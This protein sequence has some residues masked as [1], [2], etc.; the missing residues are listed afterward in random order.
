MADVKQTTTQPEA[1]RNPFKQLSVLVP[2]LGLL[3]G[4]FIRNGTVNIP[5]LNI[6]QNNSSK[7]DAQRDLLDPS[8]E[9]EVLYYLPTRNVDK[10]THVMEIFSKVGYG[11]MRTEN[12]TE[13]WHVMWTFHN[14]FYPR[15]TEP[16]PDLLPNIM[17]KLK[18]HQKVNQIPGASYFT[19]KVELAKKADKFDF[20][21]KSFVMPDQYEELLKY[22]KQNRGK[23]TWI[24]KG[25]KHRGVSIVDPKNRALLEDADSEVI[26]QQLIKPLLID[27]RMWDIGLYV[28][29][30]SVDPLRA[31]IYDNVLLRHCTQN[32]TDDIENAKRSQYVVQ[33]DY[34]P[35]WAFPSLRNYFS[36][37]FSTLNVFR[38]HISDRELDVDWLWIQMQKQIL[39]I[40]VEFQPTLAKFARK[41]PNGNTNFFSL[42]RFDFIIDEQFV[43]WL[44]EVNQSPNLSSH[45]TKDLKNMFQRIVYNLLSLNGLLKGQINH[46]ETDEFALSLIAHSNEIDIGYDVCKNCTQTCSN[47]RCYICRR[48]RAPEQSRMIKEA[49]NEHRNRQ[50]FMRLYPPGKQLM[51]QAA[52][53]IAWLNSGNNKLLKAWID[54]KCRYDFSWC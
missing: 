4:Y 13:D 50:G 34:S 21:P 42:Y 47:D 43:P 7:N 33:D 51:Q 16:D 9:N 8:F 46:P 2:V 20:V 10:L 27:G 29:I 31:Y 3:F 32:Y 54:L 11:L 5:W 36:W 30:T 28:A 18:P 45:H 19:S 44:T 14:P 17:Q 38:A 15:K 39:K 24:R 12:Y 23:L 40:L 48:C 1:S 49:V 6:Y 35:P 37:G 22:H 53:E 52:G 41:Y 26:V 25:N